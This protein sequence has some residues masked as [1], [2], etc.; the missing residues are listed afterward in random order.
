MVPQ[1]NRFTRL[2]GGQIVHISAGRKTVGCQGKMT[3]RF[4][5]IF[6]IA[7]PVALAT[8]YFV[9]LAPLTQFRTSEGGIGAHCT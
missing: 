3:G 1:G 8:A 5:D 7:E 9:I 6:A 4:G 2:H